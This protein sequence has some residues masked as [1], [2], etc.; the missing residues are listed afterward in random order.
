M[1]Q[2]FVYLRKS[3]E[4]ESEKSIERQR[5]S[6]QK[7]AKKNNIHIVEEFAEVGSSA[8]LN[9]PEL[10]RMMKEIGQRSDIDYILVYSFDRISREMDHFGWLMAQLKEIL[11]VK[12]RI[13][14]TSED[15]DYE[16]D[17]YKLF[18]IMMKTFGATEERIRI[19]SR[20]QDA[21]K[22]KQR[23]GGFLGGT[24]PMGYISAEGSGTLFI[25]EDEVP[26]VQRIFDLRSKE[27]TM[28]QVA[29]Q[30]NTEGFKTRQ[31]RDFKP[32][33]VQRVLKNEDLYR[34]KGLVPK[35]LN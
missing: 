22:Q 25:N 5:E 1:K 21:R 9:R 14:S 16:D 28:Q 8:T 23:K 30:L 32:M 7:Y 34:G 13:H 6:V 15:N 2:A 29:D 19:V 11:A 17:H 35:L 26:I 12:T 20:L 4:R 3:I 18:V 24:P 10:Q 33:T 31:G 27:M